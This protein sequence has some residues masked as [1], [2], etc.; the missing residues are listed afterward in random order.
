MRNSKRWYITF[1]PRQ[2]WSRF[3]GRYYVV[4]ATSLDQAMKQAIDLFG[5]D[6]LNVYPEDDGLDL[7]VLKEVEYAEIKKE[8]ERQSRIPFKTFREKE[9][10][11][12][13]SKQTSK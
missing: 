4:T 10:N 5:K 9:P 7:T 12:N 3:S 13:N 11:G 6:W 2:R 1:K 8:V